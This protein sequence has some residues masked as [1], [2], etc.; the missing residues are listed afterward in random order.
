MC[1]RD[2][3]QVIGDQQKLFDSGI[4]EYRAGELESGISKV[5]ASQIPLVFSPQLR[6][7]QAANNKG[8]SKIQFSRLPVPT[9]IIE[10]QRGEQTD[11]FLA[12]AGVIN[13]AAE[14]KIESRHFPSIYVKTNQQ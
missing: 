12:D 10:G 2:R 3:D 1:I 8:S 11:Q 5:I 7:P 14:L 6:E 4:A 9:L 13:E